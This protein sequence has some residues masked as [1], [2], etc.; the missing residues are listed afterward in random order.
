MKL[1]SS[2]LQYYQMAE[3]ILLIIMGSFKLP[4]LRKSYI[5]HVDLPFSSL[6]LF[7]SCIFFCSDC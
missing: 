6:I 1:F 7:L 2:K 3:N 5:Y 4:S